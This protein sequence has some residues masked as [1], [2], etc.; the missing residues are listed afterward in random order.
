MFFLR[1]KIRARYIC[2]VYFNYDQSVIGNS[3][4]KHPCSAGLRFLI[5]GKQDKDYMRG[6]QAGDI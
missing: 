1:R 4:V 6:T 5:S 3:Y 2:E